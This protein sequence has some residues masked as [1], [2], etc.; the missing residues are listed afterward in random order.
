M[1]KDD[2]KDN[3]HNAQ[4][5]EQT[6]QHNFY[7][8]NSQITQNDEKIARPQAQHQ[9]ALTKINQAQDE[10]YKLTNR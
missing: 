3:Y 9:E 6:A 1:A 7:T 5:A 4:M 8:V 10:L 2:A